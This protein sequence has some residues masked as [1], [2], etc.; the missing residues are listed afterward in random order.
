MSDIEAIFRKVPS[1]PDAYELTN[2]EF[3]RRLGAVREALTALTD[4]EDRRAALSSGLKHRVWQV[5]SVT[6]YAA[7]RWIPMREAE[8]AILAQ[9]H[10][11]V[12]VVAFQ[13]IRL[14][15]E[16]R[17]RAAIPHLTRISGWPSKFMLPGYLRKPVGIGASI[18]KWALTE[19]FGSTDPSVLGEREREF[20][21]PYRELVDSVRPAPDLSGMICIPAGPF[22]AG[23]YD[24]DDFRFEYRDFIP[25]HVVNL[26]EFYIDALPVTNA[27]YRAFTRAIAQTNHVT[28]HPDEP[29]GKDHWPSH[30]RDP[31]FAGDEMP[32]TGIDWYDAYAYAA[33]ASKQLPT[34]LQWEK[35]ARG[36]DSRDYPWGNAWRHGIANY[37]DAAFNE[38]VDN[39]QAWEH[40][41]RRV[42][43]QFPA[44]PLWPVGIHR[45][46]DSPYGVSDMAGNVWEWTRTNFYSHEDM[47]PFFRGRDVLAFTNRPAAFPVIRGGCWTSLPEMLQTSFRGKDLL[48]DRHFEIGFRCVAEA[49][50]S[51]H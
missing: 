27:A 4:P 18:T 21:E 40:L 31:R 6:I 14:C 3:A 13:A 37:V 49:T 43:S 16:L 17:L 32:V 1:P 5:R 48:T 44:T 36:T 12:D 26:P 23:T 50:A 51:S 35:A 24:R 46:A 42:D 39:L 7:G 29:P 11:S 19:I 47:D 10:D 25:S 38:R 45:E 20:L 8:E 34:E 15:G 9:T 41:L 2:A 30:L 33:W 28:C 22:V